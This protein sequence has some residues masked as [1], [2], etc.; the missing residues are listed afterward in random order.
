MSWFPQIGAGSMAQ[1]PLQRS[2]KWRAI[3]NDLES[4]ERIMLP[5][6]DAG[7]VEWRLS[8]QDLTDAE[9]ANISS[10]FSASQ[11]GFETFTFIDPMANLLGWSENFSQPGWQTGLL[12]CTSGVTDPLGTLRAS[13][14]TNNSPGTQ[15]LQQ[16]LGVPGA[17]V[18]C[19]SGYF[20]GTS[21][22]TIIISRDSVTKTVTVGPAW[23]R[24]FV[25]GPGS[26]GATQ[27]TFSIASGAGQTV[28]I[29]GLQVEAQ[30]YPSLYKQTSAALGIYEETW[31]GNDELTIA[32]TSPGL[33]SCD[34]VLVSRVSGR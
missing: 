23:Q 18:A 10:L 12:Q 9:T 1:F 32:S 11:G 33:S 30:P 21:P 26:A 22:G 28:Q 4:G 24:A 7:Q 14:L 34:I 16:T 27:S 15:Q 2:R 25:S 6:A 13:T 19:F 17:Y 5:D 31:F 3:V 29:W 20:R 8:Y